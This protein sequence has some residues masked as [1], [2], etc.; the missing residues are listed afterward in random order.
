M[1]KILG[2]WVDTYPSGSTGDFFVPAFKNL[3]FETKVI[4][5][6]RQDADSKILKEALSGE[7]EFLF[8][9]PYKNTV[10]PEIIRR[11][12]FDTKCTTIAWNGDDEWLFES[13][14]SHNPS[15]I[16]KNYNW[17]V[18]THQD[19]VNKYKGVGCDRVI[20]SQWGYPINVWKSKKL[21]KDIDIYFC[22]SR[23][24][25]RDFCLRAIQD[26]GLTIKIDGYGYSKSK[27]SQEEMINNYRRAKIA[28]SFLM[29][30]SAH[31]KESY[32]QVK[33]RVFE[34]AA[35]KTFQ[36]AYHSNELSRFFTI[37][38][39][40]ETFTRIDGLI[41]KLKFYLENDKKREAM[42][43]NAFQKNKQYSYEKILKPVFEKVKSKS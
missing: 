9:V 22:G 10:R 31:A 3:G 41:E 15:K 28:M 30:E 40:I 23:T 8:H 38:K 43:E 25:K 16:C 7:Y 14:Q 42:A 19:A 39:D 1:R 2:V 11:I 29:G 6:A 17:N 24:E 4:D 33:Q 32:T 5:L 26:F 35:L 34:V 13:E 27:I 21:K 12:S 18:T 36:I 37:G 20:L